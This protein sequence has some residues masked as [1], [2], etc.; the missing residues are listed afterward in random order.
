VPALAVDLFRTNCLHDGARGGQPV[1]GFARLLRWMRAGERAARCLLKRERM[2]ALLRW[3]AWTL[4]LIAALIG[5]VLVSGGIGIVRAMQCELRAMAR[6]H[7]WA[8]PPEEPGR[9][10]WSPVPGW[11]GAL[12]LSEHEYVIPRRKSD[13]PSSSS[14]SLD[15]PRIAPALKEGVVVKGFSIRSIAPGSLYWELGLRNHDIVRRINGEVLDS[16][17]KALETYQRLRSATRLEVELEREGKIILM[18]YWTPEWG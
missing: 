7:S 9:R 17:D 3:H 12:R 2:G 8:R 10:G 5:A 4:E 6:A 1:A 15:G 13:D 18:T 16:P 14:W 11:S